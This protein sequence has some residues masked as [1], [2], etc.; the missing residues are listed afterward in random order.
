[1]REFLYFAQK[2]FLYFEYYAKKQKYLSL[3]QGLPNHEEYYYLFV[4][5]GFLEKRRRINGNPLFTP[6]EQITSAVSLECD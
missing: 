3:H 6:Q 5:Y 4:S 2:H 1:M